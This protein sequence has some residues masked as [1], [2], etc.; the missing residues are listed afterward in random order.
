LEAIVDSVLN[1]AWSVILQPILHTSSEEAY[2][3]R[4]A[5]HGKLQLKHAPAAKK[6]NINKIKNIKHTN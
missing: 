1:R 5:T 4:F 6:S 2:E 3:D